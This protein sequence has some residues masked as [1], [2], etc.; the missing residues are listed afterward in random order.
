[1]KGSNLFYGIIL[2]LITYIIGFV[3]SINIGNIFGFPIIPNPIYGLG[4]MTFFKVPIW[5]FFGYLGFLCI[6]TAFQ[7][8]KK[9]VVQEV[10]RDI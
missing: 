5:V 9:I 7:E 2:L 10:R 1:M 6:L 3:S 4:Q 8:D